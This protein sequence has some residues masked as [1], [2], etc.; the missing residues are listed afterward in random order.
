[1]D[2]LKPSGVIELG[3]DDQLN[4]KKLL[5]SERCT[6]HE[7]LHWPRKLRSYRTVSMIKDVPKGQKAL[8]FSTSLLN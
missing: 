6:A 5:V 1:M 7:E 8:S 3:V 2:I 4:G